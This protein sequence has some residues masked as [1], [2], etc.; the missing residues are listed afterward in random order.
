MSYKKSKQEQEFRI[1][2]SCYHAGFSKT[3]IEKELGKSV[4]KAYIEEALEWEQQQIIPRNEIGALYD[5]LI[6]TRKLKKQA[7]QML[8]NIHASQVTC[9]C[10]IK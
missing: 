7:N 9:L 4:S 1:T 3:E 2:C 10:I 6:Q 8:Q 5:A